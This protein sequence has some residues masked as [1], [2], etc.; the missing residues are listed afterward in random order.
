MKWKS[1]NLQGK[2]LAQHIFLFFCCCKFHTQNFKLK[3]AQGDGAM[4]CK[5]IRSTA[6]VVG[7]QMQTKRSETQIHKGHSYV[8][9]HLPS[10]ILA[11]RVRRTHECPRN[12]RCPPPPKDSCA[13]RICASLLEFIP[14]ILTFFF[15]ILGRQSPFFSES[16]L[17]SMNNIS[18]ILSYFPHESGSHNHDS[19]VPHYKHLPEQDITDSTHKVI[20]IILDGLRY[21]CAYSFTRGRVP[22][23]DLF[24]SHCY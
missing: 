23:T 11:V 14:L 22:H 18:R 17:Q 2:F 21:D 3:F 1:Q 9:E 5:G 6:T 4:V 10:H 13:L 19:S 8:P 12:D 7:C 15:C 16:R 24:K 20:F